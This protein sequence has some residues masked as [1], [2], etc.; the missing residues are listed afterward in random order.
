MTNVKDPTL[1]LVTPTAA[2]VVVLAIDPA[3]AG[4]PKAKGLVQVN[5][6]EERANFDVGKKC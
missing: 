2:A 4:T 6:S 3:S 5:P 1:I